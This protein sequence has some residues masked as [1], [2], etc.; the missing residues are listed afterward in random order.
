M[1]FIF[2]FGSKGR[3]LLRYEGAGMAERSFLGAD[4]EPVSINDCGIY[5]IFL[6]TAKWFSFDLSKGDMF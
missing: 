1:F 6:S 2:E 5:S 4:I 3:L